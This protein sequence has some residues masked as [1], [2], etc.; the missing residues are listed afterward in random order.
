MSDNTNERAEQAMAAG[1]NSA[2][3]R[4]YGDDLPQELVRDRVYGLVYV[5]GLL[6]Y[7]LLVAVFLF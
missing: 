4:A 6:V 5:G 7:G 2:A 3:A 1:N